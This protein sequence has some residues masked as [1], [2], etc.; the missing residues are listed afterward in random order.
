MISEG[1]GVTFS[2]GIASG[3]IN[4]EKKDLEERKWVLVSNAVNLTTLHKCMKLSRMKRRDFLCFLL[5]V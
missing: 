2:N 1:W 4:G 3:K 5:T